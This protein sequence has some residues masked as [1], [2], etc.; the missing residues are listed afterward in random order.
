M[1]V[2]QYLTE[3]GS[4]IYYDNDFRN[5]LEDHMTFLRNHPLTSVI[6]LDA[7]K[8]YQFEFDL[9]GLFRFYQ[10]PVQLYWLTMRMNNRVSPQDNVKNIEIL[11]VPDHNTV[12]QIAQS[13][14]TTKR[15]N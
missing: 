12:A 5:V 1:K 6:T 9:F 7:N 2:D 14:T 3:S 8:V 10:I 4:S 13:H 11:L 15:I